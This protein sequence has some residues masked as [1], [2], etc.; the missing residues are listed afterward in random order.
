[1]QALSRLKADR[2][3]SFSQLSLFSKNSKK[4]LG[5]NPTLFILIRN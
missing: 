4:A 5:L 3:E 1:M 2:A